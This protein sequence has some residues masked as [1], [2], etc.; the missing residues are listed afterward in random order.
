MLLFP[1]DYGYILQI[2]SCAR[3]DPITRPRRHDHLPV[4]L[5]R[6]LR[7]QDHCRSSIYAQESLHLDGSNVTWLWSYVGAGLVQL[8]FYI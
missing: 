3:G 8:R 4:L 6:H 2:R 5:G 1:P 7:N